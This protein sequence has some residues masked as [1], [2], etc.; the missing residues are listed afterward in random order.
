M[1]YEFNKI[2]E[3]INKNWFFSYRKLLKYQ[4]DFFK[5]SKFRFSKKTILQD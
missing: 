1:Y 5:N 4:N 2:A 3:T